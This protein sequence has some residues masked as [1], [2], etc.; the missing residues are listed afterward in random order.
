MAKAGPKLCPCTSGDAY[1]ACCGPLHKGEREATTPE[2]LMRSRFAA[3]AMG[4]AEYLW[5][6]LHPEHEDRAS[7]REAVLR[8]MRATSR[9]LKFI[10]LT[11]LEAR[12]DRV[13]FVAGIFERGRDRSFAEVS[14]FARAREPGATGPAGEPAPWRYR[15]GVARSPV[16]AREASTW[17][18]DT[19]PGPAVDAAPGTSTGQ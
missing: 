9:A 3:F 17:T 12:G 5:R 2:A 10:R 14:T 13:L 11:V 1:A 6:T 4:D 19:F 8:A 7:D 16:D 18:L 15:D